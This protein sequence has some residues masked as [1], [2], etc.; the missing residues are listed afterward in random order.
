MKNFITLSII[1]NLSLFSQTTT[2]KSKIIDING[3]PIKNVSISCGEKGTISNVNGFFNIICLENEMLSFKHISYE[4]KDLI[5]KNVSRTI[6]LN[7]KDIFVETVVVQ[8]GLNNKI[9]LNNVDIIKDRLEDRSN[10]HFEDIINSTP[11]LNYSSGTSRPRYFQIRGIGELSQFSG[12]GAPHFYISTIIDNIDFSGIGGVGI[13]DDINQIEIFKGP[14][15]TSFGPNA[16]AG[17]INFISNKPT[18][19]NNFKSSNVNFCNAG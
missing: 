9:K 14:Q 19:K 17:A 16:M 11:T 15:S 8:G 13:I 12:E 4:P 3:Y 7:N 18:S 1:L 2:I 10:H 5:L 6:T